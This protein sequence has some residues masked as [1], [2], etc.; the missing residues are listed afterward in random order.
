MN[1]VALLVR[2][3]EFELPVKPILTCSIAGQKLECFQSVRLY[4]SYPRV[5]CRNLFQSAS[6]IVNE[7]NPQEILIKPVISS[8]L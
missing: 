6:T 8:V 5:V 1:D 4:N 2:T 3:R 7:I